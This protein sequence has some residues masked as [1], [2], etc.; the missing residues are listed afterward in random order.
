MLWYFLGQ[1]DVEDIKD[2]VGDLPDK[3]RDFGDFSDVLGCV[4][5]ITLLLLLPRD[6][7]YPNLHTH[8]ITFPVT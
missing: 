8:F 6:D 5:S 2:F 1:P 4:L 7:F 3:I